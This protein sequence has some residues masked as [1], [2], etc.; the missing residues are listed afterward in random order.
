MGKSLVAF[1][2]DH[3]KAYVFATDKLR[4]IRGGS[5]ILDYLNRD[6]MQYLA[7]DPA[8]QAQHVYTNGGGGIF[9]IDSDKA[10]SFGMHME[11]MYR[12]ITGGGSSITYAVQEL[13][14]HVAS[15]EDGDSIP[16]HLESLRVRLREKKLTP[17]VAINLATHPFMH[18]CDS[19]GIFYANPD[20]YGEDLR[21]SGEGGE[22]YCLSCQ[23]KR[24]RDR[25][26]K[27]NI[28]RK[29][30]GDDYLWKNVFDRLGKLGYALPEHPER[31]EDF[32]VLSTFKGGKDYFALIYADANG[33]G[34]A[35]EECTGLKEYRDLAKTVDETIYEA[36]CLAIARHLKISDHARPGRSANEPP[37][38]PFD[39]LMMGGDDVL[40]V[41]PATVALDVALTISREF[42][43]IMKEAYPK[44]KVK[45]ATISS[46]VVLAP[47]KYP[48]RLLESLATTTLKFAKDDGDG[49]PRI[50]FVTVAGSSGETFTKV[51]DSLHTPSREN[52]REVDKQF[53][54]TLRPYTPE[55]L[56]RLLDAIRKGR[57][58]NLGR[59]KLHQM[60]EAILKMNLT[61]SVSDS[62][63]VLINWKTDQRDFVLDFVHTFAN[64][65]LNGVSETQKPEELRYERPFPWFF[66]EKKGSRSIY[67]TPLLDFIELY[68]FV[69]GEE[70]VDGG[71]H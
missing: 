68:D 58:R 64:Q 51:F 10:N 42:E 29:L 66:S 49:E 5:S 30:P 41:V 32:N 43:R 33:M 17:Q 46:G 22:L 70:A 47:I 23:I 21:D 60:R 19:C 53:F 18:P 45:Q 9:L 57:R 63:A 65:Y 15:V 11:R 54:A 3:I 52:G 44:D 2:T 36:V 59:T 12:E 27:V 71:T 67:R 13:P 61:T 62:R 4:E 31:P 39:I 38:F 35:F 24:K 56:E 37:V 50:N 20:V 28:K 6:I 8:Y 26:V 40:M 7:D 69:S 14:D 16:G 1:D 34:K 55:A 25:D 48:F